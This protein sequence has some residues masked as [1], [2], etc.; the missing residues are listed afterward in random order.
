[1]R[2]GPS[3]LSLL[4][5]WLYSQPYL[6][7]A[8]FRGGGSPL[9]L[10]LLHL[11]FFHIMT[12]IKLDFEENSEGL[13]IQKSQAITQEYLDSLKDARFE[14]KN[15]R[16]GEFHRAAS[17]PVIIVEKWLKD[18]YDVFNEPVAKTLAKLKTENLDYF[19]TTDKQL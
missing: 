8:P 1:V 3:G 5:A 19:I 16:A 17:I 9:L 11:L 10:L 7:A 15:R 4:F 6:R 14:S 2:E 13:V 18:G 12:D